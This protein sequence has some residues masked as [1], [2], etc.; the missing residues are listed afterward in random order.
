[1]KVGAAK[2]DNPDVIRVDIDMTPWIDPAETVTVTTA[3]VSEVIS[4]TLATGSS[5]T[6]SD[7][8]TLQIDSYAVVGGTTVRLFLSHGTPTCTYNVRLVVTGGTSNRQQTLDVSVGVNPDIDAADSTTANVF[9]L[10][11]APAYWNLLPNS[12]PANAGV[13]WNNGGVICVS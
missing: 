1:M 5:T 4:G 11:I 10:N 13:A 3:P 8:D 12:L 7:T 9:Y 2:K 6:I